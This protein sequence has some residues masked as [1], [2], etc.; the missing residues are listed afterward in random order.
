MMKFKEQ[1]SINEKSNTRHEVHKRQPVT[2]T[3][4][5]DTTVPKKN[6]K[7]DDHHFDFSD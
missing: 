5:S 3:N 6:C 7:K 2:L 1:L 4:D